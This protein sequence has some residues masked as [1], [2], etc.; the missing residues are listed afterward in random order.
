MLRFIIFFLAILSIPGCEL[1]ESNSHIEKQIRS[2]VIKES[3][4]IANLSAIYTLSFIHFEENLVTSDDFYIQKD[5][6]NMDYGFD[7]D[8]KSISVVDEDGKKKLKVR[9]GQGD[10]LAVNRKSLGQPET[11]HT[12]YLP[13]NAKT[14]EIINV[15]EKMNEELEELKRIYGEK[16]IKHARENAKN[17]FRILAAKYGLEL[18]FE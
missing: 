13:K 14:G 5:L 2:E 11:S 18:D 17:F 3:S 10:V 4:G 7:L 15:D 6:V 8:D 1:T 9:L 12:G 16:N